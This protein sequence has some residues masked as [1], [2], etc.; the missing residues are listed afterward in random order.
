MVGQA[1]VEMAEGAGEAGSEAEPL[2]AAETDAAQPRP[3]AG[4]EHAVSETRPAAEP[5]AIVAAAEAM[6][7][8]KVD[9]EEVATAGPTVDPETVAEPKAEAELQAAPEPKAAAEEPEAATEEPE[10]A[11]EEPEAEIQAAEEPEAAAQEPEAA[12][13]VPEAAAAEPDAAAA[14]PEAAVAESE[15]G[16]E[17][18]IAAVPGPESAPTPALQPEPASEPEPVPEAAA[19]PEVASESAF[20]PPPV[21]LSMGYH[22]TGTTAAPFGETKN[23]RAANANTDQG[24][25]D[26]EAGASRDDEERDADALRRRQVAAATRIQAAERGRRARKIVG[27]QVLNA[28]AEAVRQSQAATRI[29]AAARGRAARRKVAALRNTRA[30][31]FTSGEV[32]AAARIQRH[33]RGHRAR[34]DV[35]RRREARDKAN[36]RLSARTEESAAIRIQRHYRGRLGRREAKERLRAREAETNAAIRELDD[37]EAAAIRIQKVYRGHCARRNASDVRARR[38]RE[39]EIDAATRIQSRYRGHTARRKARQTRR[40]DQVSM[41]AEAGDA[42]DREL[43]EA[44]AAAREHRKRAAAVAGSVPSPTPI[45]EF[46][47]PQ[48]EW[49]RS[50]LKDA[51]DDADPAS[52]AFSSELS[53]EDDAALFDIG[54]DAE[55][56]DD[57]AVEKVL[58]ALLSDARAYAAEESLEGAS[59]I[60]RGHMPRAPPLRAPSQI[61][62]AAPLELNAVDSMAMPGLTTAL[63]P[64]RP[65]WTR[66]EALDTVALHLDDST[67]SPSPGSSFALSPGA[68]VSPD[69]IHPSGGL[70]SEDDRTSPVGVSLSPPHRRR[71]N[72]SPDRYAGVFSDAEEDDYAY[73]QAHQ[74]GG[75]AAEVHASWLYARGAAPDAPSL[76]PRSRAGPLP[77]RRTPGSNRG[78][79]PEWRSAKMGVESEMPRRRPLK[80]SNNGVDGGPAGGGLGKRISPRRSKRL[81]S[82]RKPCARRRSSEYGDVRRGQGQNVRTRLVPLDDDPDVEDG[83]TFNKVR[84]E[85]AEL[86]ARKARREAAAAAAEARQAAAEERVR[87]AIEEEERE[88]RKQK[89]AARWEAQEEA[90]ARRQFAFEV[91]QAKEV[92]QKRRAEVPLYKRMQKSAQRAE[93]RDAERRRQQLEQRKRRFAPV[94]LHEIM[95]ADDEVADSMRERSLQRREEY[96]D[97]SWRHEMPPE[98]RHPHP[99]QR[100]RQ[101]GQNMPPIAPRQL[102]HVGGPPMAAP[103]RSSA[104]SHHRTSATAHARNAFKRAGEVNGVVAPPWRPPPREPSPQEPRYEYYDSEEDAYGGGH[105]YSQY[106]PKQAI[107]VGQQVRAL[108]QRGLTCSD[109]RHCPLTRLCRHA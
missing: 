89:L 18:D 97:R 45:R 83:D 13:E 50:L 3:K 10:A 68:L 53:E 105:D 8:A 85:A 107:D 70:L 82:L 63:S 31:D 108:P 93:A 51:S 42:D 54:D 52:P 5:A 65:T 57:T 15:A 64:G 72:A 22:G 95:H 2:P 1:A 46:E 74:A 49:R 59:A 34:K 80:R 6:L 55:D 48:R 30:R 99:A 19:E 16:A 86:R 24:T 91:L 28:R 39:A 58:N 109:S 43:A 35:A 9:D 25:V 4:R 36:G 23:H 103:A 79:S 77:V 17:L 92:Q 94:D 37:A 56:D 61:K 32:A 78:R 102:V 44:L 96:V 11:A 100:L 20:R 14:E 38:Q 75:G 81:D 71:P 84:R 88:R 29:Q 76:S 60:K 41:D 40:A 27:P 66:P 90:A 98:G 26:Q 101:N 12:A 67:G 47:L 73:E 7:E 69:F 33:Y 62:A 87:R 106:R 21:S 104:A